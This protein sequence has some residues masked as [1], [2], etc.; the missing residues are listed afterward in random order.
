MEKTPQQLAD[1]LMKLSQQFSAY[2]G[3][4]AGHLKLQADYFNENRIKEKSDLA[5]QRKWEATKEG[6]EMSIIKLKLK[7]LEKEMSAI[8]VF[9]RHKEIEARG[10]Y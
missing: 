7:A 9:L 3:E 10:E 5:T 4:F 2:S 1:S 8:K 6:V